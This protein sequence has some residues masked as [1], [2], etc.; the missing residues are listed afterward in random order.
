MYWLKQFKIKRIIKKVKS[1]QHARTLSQPT[2]DGLKKEMLLYTQLESIFTS[3]IGHKKCPHAKE[4]LLAVYRA[5]SGL[6]D[7]RA[8]Y[9]LGKMLLEEGKFREKLQQEG[10]FSSDS[11]ERRMKDCYKE[12]HAFLL[13]A[14]NLNHIK[15]KRLYGLCYINAWGFDADQEKGFQL[16]VESIEQENSWDKVP[17]IFKEIGLNK[18]EFFNALMSRRSK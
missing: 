12:A 6:D 14:T 17:Q 13:A 10:V 15:A 4:M 3:L 9:L 2:S 11:N 7:S 18:P 5:E 1:L 16:I 8:Q